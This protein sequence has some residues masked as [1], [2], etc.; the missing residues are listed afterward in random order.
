[1]RRKILPVLDNRLVLKELEGVSMMRANIE[2]QCAH[3]PDV[4]VLPQEFLFGPLCEHAEFWTHQANLAGTPPHNRRCT[5]IRDQL[6][7]F[8]QHVSVHTARSRF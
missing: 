3:L 2:H 6:V 7:K 4:L 5:D 1:M 8:L